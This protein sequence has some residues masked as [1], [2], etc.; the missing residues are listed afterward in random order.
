M[1]DGA[2]LPTSASYE[3]VRAFGSIVLWCPAKSSL[4]HIYAMVTLVIPRA[5]RPLQ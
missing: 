2:G 3:E 5:P 4:K 1:D